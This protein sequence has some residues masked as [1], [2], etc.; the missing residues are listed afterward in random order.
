VFA[1]AVCCCSAA[2]RAEWEEF[3]SSSSHKNMKLRLFIEVANA[4][5]AGGSGTSSTA[6]A[7]S[8]CHNST[9]SDA[10]AKHLTQLL[11]VQP[12]LTGS[13]SGILQ[14]CLPDD[15][16]ARPLPSAPLPAITAAVACSGRMAGIAVDVAAPA[17][18]LVATAEAP[19]GS[20]SDFVPGSYAGGENTMFVP[21]AFSRPQLQPFVVSYELEAATAA[22]PPAE[23]HQRPAFALLQQDVCDDE[24]FVT[25]TEAAT[26][27]L[28]PHELEAL[29]KADGYH[30]MAAVASFAESRSHNAAS[31]HPAVPTTAPGVASFAGRGGVGPA[32]GG[33]DNMRPTILVRPGSSASPTSLQFQLSSQQ[34]FHQQQTSTAGTH[35][36]DV[37]PNHKRDQLKQ[38]VSDLEGKVEVIMP[39]ELNIVR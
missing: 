30:G 18:D 11:P 13:D 12:L 22:A 36:G 5:S 31:K 17:A 1:A 39:T 21:M 15:Q 38:L 10:S 34:C 26:G 28:A 14:L 25:C 29:M 19:S 6:S 35:S 20:H 32:G 9:G 33:A 16:L 2:Y 27:N 4:S 37:G 3:V 7:P 24:E 8:S 23:L